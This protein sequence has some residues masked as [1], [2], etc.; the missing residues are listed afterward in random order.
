[1]LPGGTI[2]ALASKAV[3]GKPFSVSEYSH[4]FPNQYQAEALPLLAAFGALQ[5]WDALCIFSYHQGFGNWLPQFV[6]DNF[7]INANPVIMAMLPQL[8]QIFCSRLIQRAHREVR[9][10]YTNAEVYRYDAELNGLLGVHGYLSESLALVHRLRIGSFNA[11]VQRHA[12]EY[13][14][15]PLVSPYRSDTG[16]IE[17]DDQIGMLKVETPSLVAVSGFLNEQPIV[18]NKIHIS[19][20]AVFGTMLWTATAGHSLESAE[21]S[22]LTL[23]TRAENTSQ[24]WNGKRTRLFS[25]GQAPAR[26]E[27]QKLFL[28]FHLPVDSIWIFPL[29]ALGRAGNH[30]SFKPD[31]QGSLRVAI[32]QRTT[33][34]VWYGIRHFNKPVTVREANHLSPKAFSLSQSYPNPVYHLSA[35]QKSAMANELVQIRYTIPQPAFVTLILYDLSGRQVKPLVRETKSAGEHATAFSVDNLPSGIYFY[36]LQAGQRRAVGKML[37]IGIKRPG[38]M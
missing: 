9:L 36:R 34:N 8:A 32:D 19:N 30:Q 22:L 23:V 11:P 1:L 6:N 5:D 25:W 28:E 16:E 20:A 38:A 35:R 21:K 7:Q 18:L 33:P 27:P 31:A 17:W 2:A 3:A 24:Q 26:M 13:G 37:V 12:S 14:A 29:D 4:P 15:G 10:E